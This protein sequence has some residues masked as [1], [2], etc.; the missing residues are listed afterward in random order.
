MSMDTKTLIDRQQDFKH[1]HTNPLTSLYDTNS[2]FM[3]FACDKPSRPLSER[4]TTLL[5]TITNVERS[6]FD[7]FQ[8]H[9][10]YTQSLRNSQE[11]YRETTKDPAQRLWV[12]EK[13]KQP[14]EFNFTL[15]SLD[16]ERTIV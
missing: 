7:N 11:S 6:R 14:A 4:E 9:V 5:E 1:Q 8:A 16:N 15:E 12:L 3:K 2:K 13:A 10:N